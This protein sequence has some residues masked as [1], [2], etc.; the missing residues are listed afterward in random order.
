MRGTLIPIPVHSERRASRG[1]FCIFLV[2]LCCLFPL[3]C[4]KHAQ[5]TIGSG[6]DSIDQGIVVHT[7]N[8]QVA[9]YVL[10]PH[11]PAQVTIEFGPTTGYGLKT[12]TVPASPNHAADILVAGMRGGMVCH[13]RAIVRFPDGTVVQDTDHTFR[14]DSHFR[15][16]MPRLTV[17]Q[18]GT[19]QPGVELLDR[20]IVTY[21]AIVTDLQGHVLWAYRYPDFQSI[22]VVLLHHYEYA[23]YLQLHEWIQWVRHL[24]GARVTGKPVLWDPRLWRREAPNDLFSIMIN[25]VKLLPNG[26]FIA[27][28]GPVS[29]AL[30]D[31]PNGAP[32]PHTTIALR[33]FNLADETVQN[34][35]MSRLNRRLHAIGYKGPTIEMVHHDVTLLPDGH[36][37]VIANGTRDY[38]NLPGYPGTM[39]VIG[40]ILIELDPS[41]NP[42]W[43]WSEFDH[44]DVNHHPLGLPD[45]T[46]TNAVLYTKDDGD[47]L[48]SMRAQH[49]VIKI[50]FQNGKGTGKVLW[51]LGP[52]GDFRLI[53]GQAPGDWHYGQ[54]GPAFFGERE[55][56]VFDLGVMDNGFGRTMP[57]GKVCGMKG[58]LGCYSAA[59]IYRIDEKAKTATIIF[60]RAF[61]PGEYSWWGGNV[62]NLPNGD[63]GVDLCSVGSTNTDIYDLTRSTN[64]Q[65]VWHMHLNDSTAYRATRLGSLYPGVQW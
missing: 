15:K 5:V 57:N 32:P 34:L 65:V 37:I 7:G 10:R 54:H 46:H 45:W 52:G 18:F 49:W 61:P 14:T 36:F 6:A 60:R 38:T 30:I 43:S 64:P 8:I 13:M 25:P 35:T 62:Q 1:V 48:V 41:F 16:L 44:L 11:S 31:S 28:I 47:L 20:T 33:E 3:G 2:L 59:V 58:G 56:G 40:D 39:R 27:V 22:R 29:S 19:P 24:V 17:Q 23:A 12:W 9:R 55:A 42:V 4:R 50:D 21:Q 53:G 51:R 26:N 63:I